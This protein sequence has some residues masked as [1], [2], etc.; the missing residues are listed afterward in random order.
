LRWF[1]LSPAMLLAFS[2]LTLVTDLVIEQ[3]P[4]AGMLLSTLITP[5]VA[6]SL[7]VACDR[8]ATGGKAQW[9][10]LGAVFRV[11]ALS[12]AAI[13]LTSLLEF[14]A[15][16]VAVD[17]LSGINLLFDSGMDDAT[18][19]DRAMAFAVGFLV[20]LPFTLTPFFA[21]L[22][23]AGFEGSI[24]PSVQAFFTNVPA[25]LCYGLLSYLLLLVGIA[26]MGIG[27]VVAMPLWLAA[28][29]AALKDIYPRSGD[30]L[31]AN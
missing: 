2:G 31:P 30:V 27:V 21:L 9:G 13:L 3:V 14:A 12:I 16:A 23:D 15:Q 24:R 4:G 19:S 7:Y 5:L 8:V 17:W 26:L 11:G 6:C 20:S 1:Q 28:S 25:F 29:Y 10:D 22:D 18:S